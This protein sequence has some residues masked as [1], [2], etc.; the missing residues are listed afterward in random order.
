MKYIFQS[1]S[2]QW[3]RHFIQV[4]VVLFIVYAAANTVWRNYKI[5]HNSDRLVG[6]IHGKGWGQ[7]YALNEDMLTLLGESYK[8]SLDFLGMPWAGTVF[9]LETTDPLLVLSTVL[10]T[11]EFPPGLLLSLLIPLGIAVL[12]GKVFCS[13]LCPMRFLFEVG[14][15]VRKGLKRLGLGMPQ[16]RSNARFG[17]W[18]MVG[19]LIGSFFSSTAVWLF[20]LPYVSFSAGLFLL[21]P[22][23]AA[24]AL[25]GIAFFWVLIDVFFAPGYFCH[26]LC[27][28]GFLLEQAGRLAPFR[29]KKIKRPNVR[30]PVTPV[31]QA[32]LT[33]FRPRT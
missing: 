22:T 12:L 17:G 25:L 21:I 24:S 26:N 14:Q 4:S 3:F 32:A 8:S 19:G 18:I 9:G 2:P 20:L 28:T 11:G 30:P 16:L 27:P 1:R 29:L 31:F 13:Y 6:L 33:P 10:Q 23:G 5:A 15:A 7:L